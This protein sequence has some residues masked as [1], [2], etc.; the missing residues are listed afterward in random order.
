LIDLDKKINSIKKLEDEL[1]DEIHLE[2]NGILIIIIFN[3]IKKEANG[4]FYNAYKKI[5]LFIFLNH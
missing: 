2:V 3:I 4:S 5:F 1:L